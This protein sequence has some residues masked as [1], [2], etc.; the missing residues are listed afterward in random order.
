M[1]TVQVTDRV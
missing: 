1:V